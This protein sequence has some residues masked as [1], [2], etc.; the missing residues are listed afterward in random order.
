ML[1]G[2]AVQKS[3]KQVP[4]I[5]SVSKDSGKHGGVAFHLKRGLP[6]ILFGNSLSAKGM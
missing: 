5:A 1:Q 4:K 6:E 3:K 2:F